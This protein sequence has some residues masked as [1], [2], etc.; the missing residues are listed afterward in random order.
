MRRNLRAYLFAS[1]LIALSA[2][3]FFDAPAQAQ[4]GADISFDAFHDQLGNY[5]DWLYSDRWGEVWR[6]VRQDQDSNWR[7]CTVGHKRPEQ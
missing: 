3:P 2:G 1:S 4:I 5:G 6:P 7:P